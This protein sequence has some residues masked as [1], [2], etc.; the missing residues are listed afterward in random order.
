MSSKII[1]VKISER[2]EE[3]RL[4]RECFSI[5]SY[6]S[7]IVYIIFIIRPT[8]LTSDVIICLFLIFR[9]LNTQLLNTIKT[10]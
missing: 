7:H 4:K 6:Y 8:N 1:I 2:F 3:I 10:T 9:S 5:C